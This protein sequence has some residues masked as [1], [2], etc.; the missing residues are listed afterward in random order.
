SVKISI[1]NAIKSRYYHSLV[2]IKIGKVD[3]Q[4]T[5]LFPELKK[6][7]FHHSV[8]SIEFYTS[9]LIPSTAFQ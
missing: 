8:T 9:S 1:K 6:E 7:N 2:S 3:H 5:K 4:L